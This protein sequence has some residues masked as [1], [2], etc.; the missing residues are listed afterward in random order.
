M[1]LYLIIIGMFMLTIV[2]HIVLEW[3]DSRGN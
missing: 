1:E 3:F 2:G